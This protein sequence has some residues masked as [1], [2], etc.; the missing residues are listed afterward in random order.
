ML[1]ITRSASLFAAALL[2]ALAVPAA[3]FEEEVSVTHVTI[4]RVAYILGSPSASIRVTGTIA[5]AANGPA[6]F[7][8]IRA[9]QRGVE[10][11]DNWD[12]YWFPCTLAPQAFSAVVESLQ[13]DEADASDTCFRRGKARVEVRGEDNQV[14]ATRQVTVSRQIQVTRQVQVRGAAQQGKGS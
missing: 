10:G 6:D 8:S 2:L 13:C 11:T 9:T 5:C 14:L 12:L 4:N 7:T 1:R 3:A